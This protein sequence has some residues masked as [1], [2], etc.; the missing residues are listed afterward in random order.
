MNYL[1]TIMPWHWG[2]KIILCFDWCRVLFYYQR[3]MQRSAALCM[4]LL[5]CNSSILST[6]QSNNQPLNHSTNWLINQSINQLKN[7]SIN[8]S[9]KQ[10]ISQSIN[11]SISQS[12]SQSINQTINQ[13]VTSVLPNMRITNGPVMTSVFIWC[14]DYDSLSYYPRPWW[15]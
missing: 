13:S 7:Q 11:Q 6:N 4:Q 14:T 10:L 1:L 9:I 2:L 8:Q 15:Q 5:T 3:K 12:I